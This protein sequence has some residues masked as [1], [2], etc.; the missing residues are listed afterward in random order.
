[1]C[2]GCADEPRVGKDGE[3]LI[4]ASEV[5]E[6][7]I[8]VRALRPGDTRHLPDRGRGISF[9]LWTPAA[10][11]T[12]DERCPIDQTMTQGRERARF[13]RGAQE[14]IEHEERKGVDGSLRRFGGIGEEGAGQLACVIPGVQAG[15]KGKQGID[16]DRVAA[17]RREPQ[18]IFAAKPLSQGPARI[19]KYERP[20]PRRQRGQDSIICVLRFSE[21]DACARVAAHGSVCGPRMTTHGAQRQA[22]VPQ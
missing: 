8:R 12:G 3:R 20:G 14:L 16:R 13:K 22:L 19:D 11:E 10:A 17:A 9:G 7:P 1:M 6:R 18:N 2:A 21:E 5:G 4:D 15:A